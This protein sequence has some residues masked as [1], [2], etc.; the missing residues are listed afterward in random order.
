MKIKRVT[1]TEFSRRALVKFE[2]GITV[3][4]ISYRLHY[5]EE[6]CRAY[7]FDTRI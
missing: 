2:K 6:S 5:G 3:Y 1:H 7:M 4:L